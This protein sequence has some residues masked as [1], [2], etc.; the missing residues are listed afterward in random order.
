MVRTRSTQAHQKV[1]E[2]ALSLFSERGID[3]TSMDA[4]AETSG[5]SKATIYKHWPD[6]TAL[7]LE[8]LSFLF[9]LYE[10]R[11][12]FNSGDVRRDLIASLTYQPGGKREEQKNRIM[13]HV[14]AYAAKD[15]EFGEK[16]RSRIISA[17]RERLKEILGRGL[18]QKQ[19]V[20]VDTDVALA[21]LLG[22]M[23]YQHIFIAGK[24][25]NEEARKIA[26][27]LAV[28]VVNSFWKAHGRKK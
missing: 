3:A 27:K 15:R 2:A 28:K 25:Q 13:P 12:D 18:K 9:G 21:L 7:T 6:K 5:V 17:P 19:I 26:G 23:L 16:W 4:I 8:V 11:P 10:E 20:N 14:I 24:S 22:P 1:L